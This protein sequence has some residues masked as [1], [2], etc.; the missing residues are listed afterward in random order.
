MAILGVGRQLLALLLALSLSEVVY[1]EESGAV[2]TKDGEGK[3]SIPAFVICI[4]EAIEGCI[5][6]AVLLNALHKSGQN[7]LKKWVWFGT[8]ISVVAFVIAGGI[9]IAIFETVGKNMPP[10]GKASFEG[11]LAVFACVILTVISL[12]FLRLKD[13]I[14]KW[15]S[16]LMQNKSQAADVDATTV[17][18]RAGDGKK[19][20]WALGW[21]CFLDCI[22]DFRD[23]L[24]IRRQALDKDELENG[25]AN[26]LT[27]KDLVII[28]FSAIFREG[29]ETVIF[30]LPIS[31]MPETTRGGLVAGS[32]AGILVGIAF[33]I[34][35]LV[36]GKFV[37]LDPTWFFNLTTLFILFIAAGLSSYSMIEFEQ[38]DAAGLRKVNHPV[39]YRPAYNIGC[40]H[41]ANAR[42]WTGIID[43]HCLFPEYTGYTYFG[44]EKDGNLGM[45]FRAM[46]GYRATPTYLMG[47][48][49]CL[50]WIIV[51]SI[52][53]WRYKEGTL[54]TRWGPN[55]P[56][57]GSV[58][59]VKPPAADGPGFQPTAPQIVSTMAIGSFAPPG[60]QIGSA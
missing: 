33:G 22:S 49:Y 32:C 23:A 3:F 37:L 56:P 24:N 38:I 47:I 4:R 46:L 42:I 6:V 25:S 52:M 30:L 10:A 2:I 12:K 59:V 48:I 16:K 13:L 11:V 7:H 41:R 15:E 18:T 27:W 21:A 34:L 45:I 20:F 60:V 28:T 17:T 53:M 29:L 1:A 5:I 55:G 51:P 57:D 39:F 58:V 35:V 14:M 43:T 19:G 54:F 44:D 31:A 26:T 9:C 50:Y 8:I 40:L 36:I